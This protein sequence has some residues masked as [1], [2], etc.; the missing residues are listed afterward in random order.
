MPL[1]PKVPTVDVQAVPQH[2]VVLDVR[3]PDEW[4][5]GHI[6]GAL[7]VPMGAIPQRL[8][9]LPLDQR[10][11]VVCRSGGRSSRV[12]AYL[13]NQGLDAVNLDGG[14]R[15]WSSSGRGMVSENGGDP[16]VI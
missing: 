8:E 15:A 4:A 7:H 9:E 2:A 10:M 13:R 14:M 6:E 11:V 16:A 5:A 12:T 3:E 1:P